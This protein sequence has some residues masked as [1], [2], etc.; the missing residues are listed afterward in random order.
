MSRLQSLTIPAHIACNAG[1]TTARYIRRLDTQQSLPY[2]CAVSENLHL[3]FCIEIRADLT[4]T[5]NG[6]DLTAT[7]TI[8]PVVPAIELRVV[9]RM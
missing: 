6:R 1:H 8:L 9:A 3:R 2:A 4:E 5:Q 7:N